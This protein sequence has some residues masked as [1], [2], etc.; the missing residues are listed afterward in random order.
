MAFA[1]VSVIIPAYNRAKYIQQAVDSVLGQTY[2][3]LE[4]I[5]VDDGSTDRTYELLQAYGDRIQLV[6]HQDRINRG[7]SAAINLG[8]TR[9]NGKYIAILDSDDYWE[10][11]KL[12]V[13]VAFLEANPDVGLVYTNGYCVNAEGDRLYAYHSSNHVE[14]NDPNRVLLDCYM[15]LPVNSL[16]RKAVYDQVGYF[17]E[18][19]RAAQDH[20]MLL[21]IAEVA[22]FA[23]LPDYL[24]Y[25]RRHS[26]SISHKKLDVRWRAGFEILQRAQNRYPYKKAT[27]R[28]RRAVLHYRLATEYLRSGLYFKALS[29]LMT[30]G[31]LDPIRSTR[32]LLGMEKNN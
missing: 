30:A 4:L 5:V 22:K 24:F 19:F 17:E 29:G 31:L 13:Q 23:Y 15:A 21:R 26:D 20:D 11:N 28:K 10:L 25:Y 32:V 2:R 6:H 1:L 12:E 16:V 9:A 27:I 7:Q 18:S 14:P 3:N 8:L